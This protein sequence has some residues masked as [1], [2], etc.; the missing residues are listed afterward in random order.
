MFHLVL[1]LENRENKLLKVLNYAP[2]AIDTD[3]TISLEESTSLDADLSQ[4]YNSSRHNST[5]I[6]PIATSERLLDIL[7]HDNYNTGDHID[8]WDLEE[9]A[10]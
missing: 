3:M 5:Y 4:F 9:E 7:I 6:T 10:K 1:G 8:Y 2:G